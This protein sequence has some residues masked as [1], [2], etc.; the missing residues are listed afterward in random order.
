MLDPLCKDEIA[1]RVLPFQIIVG[2]LFAGCAVF[3]VIATV[4]FRERVSGLPAGQPPIMTYLAIGFAVIAAAARLIIPNIIVSQAR[5]R[6]IDGTWHLPQSCG[7]SATG[8]ASQEDPA[9]FFERTGD[10]GKL[11]FVLFTRTIVAGAI[12]EGAA[13]AALTM[14]LI[15]RSPVSLIVAIILMI[16]VA[17]HF[18]TRSRVFS[19]IE[20]QMD[21]VRQERQFGR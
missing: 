17:A 12:L 6:I 21:L 20:E 2:C 11:L 14:Y 3:F 15:E 18:P 13:I 1:R 5:R 19:W 7:Q 4:G 10:A 16:A 8:R 9:G